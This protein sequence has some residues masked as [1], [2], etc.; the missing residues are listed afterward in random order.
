MAPS[1]IAPCPQY[2]E[3][4]SSLVVQRSEG[5]SNPSWEE[6]RTGRGH[7]TKELRPTNNALIQLD[8]SRKPTILEPCNSSFGIGQVWSFDQSLWISQ[9]DPFWSPVL[10]SLGEV[11]QKANC[12]AETRINFLC[13]HSY[14]HRFWFGIN[15]LLVFVLLSLRSS[16]A[17]SDNSPS[18]W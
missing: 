9:F 7:S 13:I 11:D 8:S 4:H 14:R 12:G 2:S 5:A 3:R 18:T 15:S 16:L 17:Y 10:L 6:Q 1:M